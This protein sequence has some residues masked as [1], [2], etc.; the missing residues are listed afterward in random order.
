MR[1]SGPASR[2]CASYGESAAGSSPTRCEASCA[3]CAASSA[4]TQNARRGYSTSAALATAWPGRI[5]R[6][7]PCH[8]PRRETRERTR[9]RDRSCPIPLTRASRLADRPPNDTRRD[10]PRFGRSTRCPAAETEVNPGHRRR[11]GGRRTGRA[12]GGPFMSFRNPFVQLR[13]VSRRTEIPGLRRGT[14]TTGAAPGDRNDTR[15]RAGPDGSPFRP[16]RRNVI[17][18]RFARRGKPPGHVRSPL[19]APR[20]H[21]R[22]RRLTDR[23]AADRRRVAR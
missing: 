13:G 3:S 8:R 5:R 15:F 20:Q 22:S 10:R 18:E 17:R 14:G 19:R 4:I 2:C 21:A 9:A 7:D 16:G 12:D 6:D 23:Q 1:G 11:K